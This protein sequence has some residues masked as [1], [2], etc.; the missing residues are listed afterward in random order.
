MAGPFFS[1]LTATRDRAPLLSEALES[2][3][4]QEFGDYEHIIID[5]VSTDATPTLLAAHPDLRVI[6][7]PDR[8]FYD[9]IHKGLRSARGEIIC[10]LN[11][12]DLLAVGALSK[13]AA[14]FAN[15]EIEVVTG[16]VEFFRKDTDDRE[17][18]FAAITD[19][20]ALRLN[21]ENALTG[22]P[23]FNAH[24]FRQ[25]FFH[26]VGEFDLDLAIA[27]DRDW[28]V[29]A[30]LLEPRQ[31]IIPT[32]LYRY[33]EHADSMTV[34]GT[35]KNVARWRGEH[36]AFAEKHLARTDLPFHA[37][38]ALRR[39]H[40]RESAALAV[41]SLVSRRYSDM[42]A[43]AHRGLT[44]NRGW[45]LYASKRLLGHALGY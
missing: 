41:Q 8:G 38:R 3:R 15:P 40:T 33:R 1:I 12:D 44:Q 35:E 4:T 43:W 45:F 26:R 37:R 25:S 20:A 13:V 7:E 5:A 27:A 22:N 36:V 30:A 17:Q 18:L 16:Q 10:C 39:F 24:F 42:R 11:S 9:G 31:M 32:P 19:P 21:L 6:S 2:V 28:L 34:H 23:V 14:A 29:R